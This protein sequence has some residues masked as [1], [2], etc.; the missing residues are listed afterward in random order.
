MGKTFENY[1]GLFL[2]LLF[3]VSVLLSTVV[4]PFVLVVL[5]LE[6]KLSFYLKTFLGQVFAYLLPIVILLLATRQRAKK[7]FKKTGL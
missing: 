7:G 6:T 1:Q 3:W 5:E 2:L 4:L